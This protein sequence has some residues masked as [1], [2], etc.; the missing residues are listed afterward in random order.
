MKYCP[1]CNTAHSKLGIFCSRKC[2]NS[3]AWTPEQNLKRADTLRGVS[4]ER[5]PLTPKQ[6]AE[7]ERKR[8]LTWHEKYLNTPFNELKPDSKRRR[9]LEEQNHTCNRCKLTEWQG[10]PIPLELEHKD[11]DNRN[12]IRENLEGLCPN[13]HALTETWRGRNVKYIDR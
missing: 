9:V 10:K 11:G 6:R 7:A 2:A 3:R 5:N 1:K 13:C 4:K 12:N 8:K